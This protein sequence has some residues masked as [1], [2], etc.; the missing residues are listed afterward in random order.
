VNLAACR[1]LL[2]RPLSGTW[3]RALELEFLKAPLSTKHTKKSAGRFTPGRQLQ[4]SFAILY[5]CEHQV[6]T[7]R[8][9]EAIY[10]TLAPGR[11]FPDPHRAWALINPDV[12]LRAVADLTDPAHLQLL[13]TSVQELTGDW[14][15]YNSKK[16]LAPTQRLCMALFKIPQLEGFLTPSAKS[17]DER[18]LNVFPEKLQKGSRIWFRNPLSGRTH[19]LTGK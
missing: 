13:S 19:S 16:V 3:Y 12:Q 6:L 4:R 1:K 8:E 9:V 18:N 5:L 10:G 15:W 14:R 2:L 11:T 7:L 17:P